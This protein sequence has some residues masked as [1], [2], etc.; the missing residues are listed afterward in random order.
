[1]A[2]LLRPRRILS[3]VEAKVDSYDDRAFLRLAMLLYVAFVT[4]TI[5]GHEIWF[6]EMQHWLIAKD[7]HSLS[8]LFHNLRYDGH[9]PLWHLLLY[10]LS[11]LTHNPQAMQVLH[12]LIATG[13]AYVFLRFA[14]LKRTHKLLF[15]F[16][17]FPVYEYAVISRNYGMGI[18]L[19]FCF[20]ATL[21]LGQRRR[22]LLLSAILALLC[23]T[24]AYGCIIAV[25]LTC[26]L[27]YELVV[28]EKARAALHGKW[29]TIAVCVF[30]VSLGVLVSVLIAAP[31]SNGQYGNM[32]AAKTDADRLPETLAT[33]WKGIVPIPRLRYCYWDSNIFPGRTL[34]S[35]F[36]VFLL[37]FML[38][39][40]TRK[41]VVFFFACLTVIMMLLFKYLLYVGYVR[42]HGHFFILL[43][44][45]LWLEKLYSK[46]SEPKTSFFAKAVNFA[47]SHKR[48][49]INT[50]LVIHL[51]VG[52]GASAI[53]WVRPFSQSKNTARY[54]QSNGLA[55]LPILGDTD[56]STPAVA[57]YLDRPI[58][59]A[60]RQQYGSFVV[61]DGKLGQDF[62]EAM[63]LEEV[64]AF[65]HRKRSDVL[66]L[67]NYELAKPFT[68]MTKLKEFQG[69]IWDNEDFYLYL[70]KYPIAAKPQPATDYSSSLSN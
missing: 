36:S 59:Y 64:Q 27:L 9:P 1:M 47:E 29:W 45:C 20:C 24:N 42:H 61:F 46:D 11:R 57:G 22:Y 49:F 50:L 23:Q 7:S 60:R 14:P 41:R 30:L 2:F 40:F 33:V 13:M 21:G 37:P 6:D 5:F 68:F 56:T 54:I 25:C 44:V 34:P 12:L 10:P 70:L 43:I 19:I 69:S 53:D 38:L 4:V 26:M 32:W 52:I 62:A 8:D 3:K 58:Y 39:L 35:I 31:E 67:L 17:Y 66:I 55:N 15:I 51:A 18:L 63:L 65:A 28:D 48:S 16:G